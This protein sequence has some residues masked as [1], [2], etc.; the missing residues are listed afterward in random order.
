MSMSTLPCLSSRLFLPVRSCGVSYAD[1]SSIRAKR[2][3][4]DCVVEMKK[5]EERKGARRGMIRNLWRESDGVLQ[6]HEQLDA[7][8]N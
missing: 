6:V 3:D 4:G 5:H 1:A 8:P 7:S 2:R